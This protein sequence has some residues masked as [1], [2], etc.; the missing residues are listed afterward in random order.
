MHTKYPI[1]HSSSN[2][3]FMKHLHRCFIRQEGLGF[4]PIY[5]LKTQPATVSWIQ[6]GDRIRTFQSK[7]FVTHGTALRLSFL[8]IALPVAPKSHGGPVED[9][10]G[11][12]SCGGFVLQPRDVSLWESVAF[13]ESMLSVLGEALL[14]QSWL[15]ANTTLSLGKEQRTARIWHS[16]HPMQLSGVL[17]THG[18]LPLLTLRNL[19]QLSYKQYVSFVACIN[20]L[21]IYLWFQSIIIPSFQQIRNLRLNV[22]KKLKSQINGTAETT[23]VFLIH[24]LILLPLDWFCFTAKE[25]SGYVG[26][27]FQ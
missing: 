2:H 20:S 24:S 13:R 5:K 11:C 26:S 22:F 21:H 17:R 15:A 25:F 16:W 27:V 23:T 3:E 18:G 4:P 8:S 10:G 6:A 7:D 19:R 9:S 14:L 12:Y 1:L